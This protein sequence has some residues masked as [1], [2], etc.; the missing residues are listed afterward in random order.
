MRALYRGFSLHEF[1]KRGTTKLTNLDLV[2]LNLL[3]HIYTSRGERL[4]MTTFGTRIPGLIFEQLDQQAVDVVTEDLNYVFA[5]D[6]RV[7]LNELVVT[8]IYERNAILVQ[9]DLT[10]LE[11]NVQEPFVIQL[12]FQ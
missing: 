7:R 4:N 3:T 10:Y 8:P 2:K 11:L 5:Y 12:T 6:P 1:Q 9:A